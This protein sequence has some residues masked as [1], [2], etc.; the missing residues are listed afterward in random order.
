MMDAINEPRG[1]AATAAIRLA[2]RLAE[3]GD[4]W[5]ELLIPLLRRLASDPVA[6]VRAGILKELPY[7]HSKEPALGWD[8]LDRCLITPHPAL[9]E[10]AGEV[11]YYQL[12]DQFD[13]VAPYLNRML[14]ETPGQA[15][16]TWS[17]LSA[18][19]V[20]ED[21]ITED[22]LF[23]SLKTLDRPALWKGAASVFAA[24]IGQPEL[25]PTC[26]SGLSRI[27]EC[28]QTGEIFFALDQRPMNH[29]GFHA[30]DLRLVETFID[31][32]GPSLKRHDFIGL[33][34]W[35]A[36]TARRDPFTALPLLEKLA[37]NLS[38]IEHPRLLFHTKPLIA[39]L[40]EVLREADDS[41]DTQLIA[42]AIALQDEYLTLG[43]S[44]MEEMLDKA[45]AR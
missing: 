20:L 28:C 30:D 34:E 15:D 44:G 25:A 32:I 37:I 2:N 33:P 3:K 7:L 8:L 38:A 6:S 5:P 29:V 14:A 35:L 41:D 16:G 1:I 26:R 36:T 40:L 22:D 10:L 31:R 45:T 39:A 21:H 17:R 4:A 24:N 19:A 18:L 11:F 42:R 13:R 27:L 9:W 12:R 23:H 43:L